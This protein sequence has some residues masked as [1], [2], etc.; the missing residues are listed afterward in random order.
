MKTQRRECN[1]III[2][3]DTFEAW[4]KANLDKDQLHDLAEHGADSGWPGLTYYTDTS[5]IYETFKEEIWTVVLDIA[6]DMGESVFEFLNNTKAK[7][8]V[9]SPE[10]FECYMVWIVAEEYARRFTDAQEE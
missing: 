5:H 7:E 6:E 3:A 4:L 9:G 10:Q 1:H 8:N 2:R